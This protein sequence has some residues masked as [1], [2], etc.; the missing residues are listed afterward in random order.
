MVAT[1]GMISLL[2]GVALPTHATPTHATPTHA[3]PT[4]ATAAPAGPSNCGQVVTRPW[5]DTRLSPDRRAALLLAAMTPDERVQL[6]G[7]D[8]SGEGVHT[9]AGY[10][11]P[12]LGIPAV[13]YTDGPV[14]PRQGQATAMP[15]PMALAATFDRTDAA[16]YGAEVANEA[17]AKGNDVV[18]GPTVNIMRTPQGGRTYEAYGEDPFL[19]AST[20]VGWIDGAQAQG[21]MADVKHFVANNQEGQLGVAPVA[22]VLGGRMLVDA[23]VDERTLREVYMPQFEAAVKQA[24]VATVMCSYNRVNGNYACENAH[25]IQQ[26][27]ERTW[28]FQGYVLADYGA[29]HD[30]VAN[31]NNGLDFEPWPAVAYSPTLIKVALASGL[32][33]WSTVD[34]HVARIL[35][36]M[37]AYGVFDRAPYVNNDAQINW[38]AHATTAQQ[39]EQQAITLLQNKGGILP[40]HAASAG[41][42]GARS[43]AVIGPYANR[44]VTGGGSGQVSPHA[45]VTALAGIQ[46]RTAGSGTRVTYNDGSDAAAAAAAARAASVAVVVVGDIETEG[47]DKSCI[48]LNCSDDVLN[49][50]GMGITAAG[51]GCSSPLPPACPVN[52]TNEDGLV[53]AVA[54]ANPNTV[55]VL[56]TGAP[57][58]TPWRNQ[59]KGIVEAWYPGQMGGSALAHVLFGDVDPGGRLPVTF[60]DNPGQLPT[61]GSVLQYPGAGVEE[62]YTE[63]VDV[64]YRWYDAHGLTPAFPFGSGLSYTSFRYHDVTVHPGNPAGATVATVTAEITNTGARTGT[65]VPQLYLSLPGSAAVTQPP[66]ELKGYASLSLRPGQTVLVSFLLND[67]SFAYYDT[68]AGT[69]RVA[70]GCYGVAVGSSSRDLPLH[71]VIARGDAACGRAATPLTIVAG[72]AARALPLP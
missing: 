64:G 28:G 69:W 35:R 36:T 18:F 34:A 62:Y 16:A 12:R 67:R 61:A 39:I 42:A 41:G 66:R 14:G 29:A 20:T 57:V 24:H 25:N 52:G 65:A 23:N 71:A 55:V 15:I 7:G 45:V 37:F 3:T 4:H 43:I 63:G 44:F 6:L 22:S 60:P 10:A 68:G 32:V 40:L 56:E 58:L 49:N 26:V 5:C 33:T 31:L 17:K 46:A 51:A 9:G 47:Q 1:A 11:I 8:V 30:T 19:V 59:V 38:T 70:P 21:V 13:Y 50:E 48:D 54:A 72:A 27:L 53:S 2:P